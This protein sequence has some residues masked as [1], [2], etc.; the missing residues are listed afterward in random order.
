[1]WKGRDAERS[2]WDAGVLDTALFEIE[3]YVSSEEGGQQQ[4]RVSLFAL[5]GPMRIELEPAPKLDIRR[6]E[7]SP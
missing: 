4:P 5:I 2:R 1:M 7:R 6:S 3:E